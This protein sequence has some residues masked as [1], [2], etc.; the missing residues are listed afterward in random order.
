MLH[1]AVSSLVRFW[2]LAVMAASV[3]ATAVVARAQSCDAP[4]GR[5]LVKPPTNVEAYGVFCFEQCKLGHFRMHTD[6][7][8]CGIGQNCPLAGDNGP[9]GVAIPNR[10]CHIPF[11][12]GWH[13]RVR[14]HQKSNC[15]IPE[16]PTCSLCVIGYDDRTPGEV[17]PGLEYFVYSNKFVYTDAKPNTKVLAPPGV[18]VE[19]EI[20][21][22][23]V[24]FPIVPD[25]D[26]D[27]VASCAVT[28]DTCPNVCPL[29]PKNKPLAHCL[30]EDDM[31]LFCDHAP[32]PAMASQG[33]RVLANNTTLA[34]LP[35]RYGLVKVNANA[36]L[37]LAAG[38]Y[39]FAELR[40]DNAGKVVA[41]GAVNL[42]VTGATKLSGDFYAVPAGYA[43]DLFTNPAATAHDPAAPPVRVM[44]DPSG[45]IDL[46]T[47]GTNKHYDVDV[48]YPRAGGEIA[49]GQG[50]EI[51]GRLV[52]WKVLGGEDN[53]FVCTAGG[54]E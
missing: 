23:W 27:G 24:D 26:D 42:L 6:E 40:I 19:S 37:S 10:P 41:I 22:V 43:G 4:P 25:L 3:I 54:A 7:A 18:V 33:D 17:Y 34:L 9:V 16:D 46:L 39:E 38:D 21:E 2:P 29:G 28:T 11:I 51:R 45:A 5:P 20:D 12:A 50:N 47:F 32:V 15:G 8:M 48:C 13:L 36:K 53:D 49:P 30:D 31:R 14:G 35:G 1:P 52:A 44:V